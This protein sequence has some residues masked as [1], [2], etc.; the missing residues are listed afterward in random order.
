VS[1]SYDDTIKLW[2][3]G[4]DDWY[5][6]QTLTGHDSTVWDVSFDRGG[7]RL[8]SC[9][10]DRSLR[11]WERPAPDAGEKEMSQGKKS[12]IV[13]QHFPKDWRSLAVVPEAHS[14]VVYS[15]DF[16]R[17]GKELIASVGGDNH[18]R[19]W[20]GEAP[21]VRL[22]DSQSLGGDVNC[23]RW[24]PKEQGILASCGDDKVVR[25]WKFVE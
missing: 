23:V 20:T 19:V 10:D 1:C 25:V 22:A 14:R 13:D 15:V 4:D 21:F 2:S 12:D 9:S 8:V 16:S 11:V 18:L 3:E 17:V 24:N 5:C 7:S 6:R